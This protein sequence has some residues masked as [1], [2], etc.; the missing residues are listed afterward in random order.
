ME[1]KLLKSASLEEMLDFVKDEKGRSRYG[2]GMIYFDL[3]GIAAYGHG[4]G[5]LVQVVAC[6]IFPLIR[7]ILSFQ[8]TSAFL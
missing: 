4:G 5:V 1:G 8:R 2:M 3:G 7:Y 6:Y